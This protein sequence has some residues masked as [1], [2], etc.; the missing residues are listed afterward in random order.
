MLCYN[1]LHCPLSGPDLTYI[2]LLIIYCII[3][4]VTNKTLNP[5]KYDLNHFC[6]IPESQT[7]FYSLC[8]SML[9]S[10][11]S[12]S[13]LRPSSTRNYILP[14]SELRRIKCIILILKTIHPG[15]NMSTCES[16]IHNNA[17]SS[18]KK[19]SIPIVLLLFYCW[20]ILNCFCL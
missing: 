5:W 1:I 7:Q 8:R 18:K 15:Q 14:V 9:W 13:T 3:E 19:K 4:Y 12:N 10:P 17:S 11:V 6:T 2:S 16:I 20:T